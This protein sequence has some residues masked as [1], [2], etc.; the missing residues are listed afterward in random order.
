[1]GSVQGPR[2]YCLPA[3]SP[4]AASHHRLAFLQIPSFQHLDRP[5]RPS[6]VM[7]YLRGLLSS[8]HR[9]ITV[10]NVAND[11]AHLVVTPNSVRRKFDAQFPAL[12]FHDH[13]LFVWF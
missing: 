2:L 10:V 11:L 8:Q 12:L 1:M 13:N 5:D 6:L 4:T 9:V 3:V 7:S